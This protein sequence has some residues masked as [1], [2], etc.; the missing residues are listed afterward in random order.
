VDEIF[1]NCHD[2]KIFEISP[3]HFRFLE[4]LTKVVDIVDLCTCISV[5]ITYK[6]F[7]HKKFNGNKNLEISKSRNMT[8]NINFNHQILVVTVRTTIFI[9]QV[10]RFA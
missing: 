5:C 4:N 1:I 10:L 2:R 6:P 8:G 9:T 7:S 3:N